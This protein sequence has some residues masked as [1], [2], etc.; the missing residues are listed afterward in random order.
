LE[1]IGTPKS[2]DLPFWTLFGAFWT[3]LGFSGYQGTLKTIILDPFWTPRTK[4]SIAKKWQSSPIRT[5]F[6]SNFGGSLEIICKCFIVEK[7]SKKGPKRVPKTSAY[8]P[9]GV[10]NDQKGVQNRVFRGLRLLSRTSR[11]GPKKGPK[12][13]QKGVPNGGPKGV[14]KG[15]G[16]V[17]G[18]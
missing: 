1:Q 12:R 7:G 2:A 15:S 14:Q 5:P 10:Q 11:K 3:L 9:F 4:I 16:G 17:L 13:V 8:L 6:G 18:A